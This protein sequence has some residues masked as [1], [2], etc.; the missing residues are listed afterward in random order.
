MLFAKF[1]YNVS[2]PRTDDSDLLIR[3]QENENIF[4]TFATSASFLHTCKLG[5]QNYRYKIF[6]IEWDK[7]DKT[8]EL[9]KF[10]GG[11]IN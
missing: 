10:V 5:L 8:V 4:Q 1:D 2:L 9:A 11:L 3:Q 7:K 6:R